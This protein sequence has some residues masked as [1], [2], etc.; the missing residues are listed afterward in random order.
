M[1]NVN[2]YVNINGKKL[3][4]YARKGKEV[5]LPVREIEIFD[6]KLVDY[7]ED[8]IIFEAHVSK[9]TYIRTLGFDIAKKLGTVGY[10]SELCRLNI[11]PFDLKEAIDLDKVSDNSIVPTLEALRR[12]I[13][14]I[15]V[16]NQLTVDIKNGKVKE[17][18]A[19]IDGDKLIISDENDNLVALFTKIEN[20]F[21]FRR[22][23]F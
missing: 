11:G 15:S 23:L 21:I 12:F 8:E 1:R 9:G 16:N 20:K 22:G 3:Y 7:K 13:P 19:S 17:W 2:N 10:L 6:I 18:D 4:E 14:V 5:E